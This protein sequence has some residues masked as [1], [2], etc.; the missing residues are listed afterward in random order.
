MYN[1]TM[2]ELLDS[3]LTQAKVP[4]TITGFK[5]FFYTV[6]SRFV[7]EKCIFNL[8]GRYLKQRNIQCSKIARRCQTV[9]NG[10]SKG[11]F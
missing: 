5:E 8:Y 4:H 2:R 7:L 6:I 10:E 11:A 3:I 1:R 9:E